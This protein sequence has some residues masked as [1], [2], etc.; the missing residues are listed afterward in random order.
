MVARIGP[1]DRSTRATP[2]VAVLAASASASP[3][4]R[5]ISASIN[6]RRAPTCPTAVRSAAPGVDPPAAPPPPPP[7]P[8]RPPARRCSCVRV[9]RVWVRGPEQGRRADVPK[10]AADSARGGRPGPAG[11]SQGR[12]RSATSGRTTRSHNT[13]RP[14]DDPVGDPTSGSAHGAGSG[15]SRQSGLRV[16][17]QRRSKIDPLATAEY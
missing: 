8:P 13:A 6:D 7:P 5:V 10:P 14:S 3:S 4:Q 2:H 9:G 11:R 16:L 1:I 17:C 15:P 12:R